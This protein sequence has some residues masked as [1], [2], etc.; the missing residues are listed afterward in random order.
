[1]NF[2]LVRR[3]RRVRRVGLVGLVRRVGSNCIV[4]TSYKLAPAGAS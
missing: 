4:G 2:E 1:M 3:V